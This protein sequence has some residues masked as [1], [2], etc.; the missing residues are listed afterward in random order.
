MTGGIAN[1][2]RYTESNNSSSGWNDSMEH[3]CGPVSWCGYRYIYPIAG[4]NGSW[5]HV[6]G[7]GTAIIN[8]SIVASWGPVDT[9][10]YITR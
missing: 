7:V 6:I 1:F 4:L 8:D 5:V 3:N 2:T 10:N 9:W